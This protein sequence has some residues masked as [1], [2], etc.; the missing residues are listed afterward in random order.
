[1]GERKKN[2][3]HSVLPLPVDFQQSVIP[4]EAHGKIF[5]ILN[6]ALIHL[7][8]LC[9]IRVSEFCPSGASNSCKINRSSR[10]SH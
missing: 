6:Q 3:L 4:I 9:L 2:C 7:E 8:F 1:M 10:R 5:S